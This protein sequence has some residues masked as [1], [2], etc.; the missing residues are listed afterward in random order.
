MISIKTNQTNPF[1]WG[2]QTRPQYETTQ[3]I[4]NAEWTEPSEGEF[5]GNERWAFFGN[6]YPHTPQVAN[7]CGIECPDCE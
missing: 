3:N 1:E 7:V 4:R 5:K 6:E 2:Y